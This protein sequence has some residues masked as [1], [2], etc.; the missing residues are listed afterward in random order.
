MMTNDNRQQFEPNDGASA[1]RE[2]RVDQAH[3]VARVEVSAGVPVAVGM[4]RVGETDEASDE[5]G[6]TELFSSGVPAEALARHASELA[7]KLQS[8]L[9]DL[10]RRESA[11]HGQEAELDSRIRSA[12][13][14]LEEREGELDQREEAI[15][16]REASSI[17]YANVDPSQQRT[18]DVTRS[19]QLEDRERQVTKLQTELE[20]IQSELAEKVSELEIQNAFCQSKQEELAAARREVENR[21]RELDVREAEIYKQMEQLTTGEVSLQQKVERINSAD[22]ELIKRLDDLRAWELK[23]GETGSELEF[24]RAELNRI[25]QEVEFRLHEADERER[26]IKFR[27][28]E[29]KTALVRFERLNVTEQKMVELQQR[30]CEFDARSMNLAAAESLLAEQHVQLSQVRHE[31]EQQELAFENNVVRQ[32]QFL[33]KDKEQQSLL[34]SRR[35]QVLDQREQE[36]DNRQTVLEQLQEELRSAQRE[37]LEIRLATEETWLQLQGAL[38]PATL[39]RSISQLRVRLADHFRLAADEAVKRRRELEKVRHEL[40][41]EHGQLQ[42]QR[43]DLEL[44]LTRREQELE[45]HASRLVERE[46]DLDAQQKH[47]ELAERAWQSQQAEYQRELQ[48]LLGQERLHLHSAA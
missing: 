3:P 20:I 8:R 34:L 35:E 26:R 7:D 32:R 19:L 2:M 41:A 46:Q 31:L 38:A 30:A 13:L 48:R 27:E 4:V 28:Q 12:R 18:A 22:G 45:Q 15:E 5:F 42:S 9:S 25:Q 29:I 36:L 40:S 10:D 44:W 6:V 37:V 39:S 24:Q 33:N 43:R 47:Y 14:W 1:A 17:E 11:L 21:Q 23:L 16:Q